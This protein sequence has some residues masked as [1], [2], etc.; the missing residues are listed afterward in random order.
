MKTGILLLLILSVTLEGRAGSPDTLRMP[1]DVSAAPHS[2][3]K[4][5]PVGMTIP[6]HR[7]LYENYDISRDSFPQNE[8]SVK[9]N[10]R[11]PQNVV[12]AWRDF[13]TG[14][15]PAVR[16]IGYSYSTDGGTTWSPSM[17]LPVIDTTHPRA[18]DPVVSS[19]T[20]GNFYVATIS[21]TNAN[22]NG[23]ILIY[24]STDRGQTFPVAYVAQGDTGTYEDKEWMICDLT[25][26]ISLYKN[27]LYLA[28][29][30][31]QGP[32]QGVLS[33]K[34]T[35]G[36]VNWTPPLRMDQTTGGVGSTQ[37]VGAGG[38]LYTVWQWSSFS[39]DLIVFVRSTDG[40]ETF[41]RDT[42]V[43]HGPS[44]LVPITP[45]NLT[46]PSIAA[47]ISNGPMRGNVYVV[48]SDARNGDPDIFLIKSTNSGLSWPTPIRVNDDSVGN[49][50]LQCWP[51]IAANDSGQLAV[52][53]YDARSTFDNSVVEAWLATSSDGGSTFR[54]RR[55]SSVATP[56]AWP[57]LDVRFGEY[58]NVDYKGNR[59]VPVWTDERAGG[60]DMDIYTAIVDLS[61]SVRHVVSE[62]PTLP[63]LGQ[64][65]P[66]PFNPTTRIK[67]QVPTI[68]IV[69]LKVFDVL[70]REVATLVN[71]KLS[72]GS[73][74][75]QFVADHLAS[76]VYF[77]RL[78]AGAYVETKRMLLL[79]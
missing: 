69:M 25:K 19:D 15:D 58:I 52:L 51:W 61:S 10:A 16:R 73:Y 59:I 67:F 39:E 79:R 8:P 66:N 18:S 6:A 77:Y 12:A 35:D 68:S 4:L 75:V 78:Q 31:A 40:G 7:S 53:Y 17:L 46:L 42:I 38:E 41:T 11:Y 57:N 24:K 26:G 36:G 30:R 45:L 9:F 72:S 5:P 48:W 56:S 3:V 70:G 2:N 33:S 34:S 60:Y 37:A 44:P 21:I 54:N 65:Y 76:G 28:W 27:T 22:Q 49:G 50:K 62:V 29:T 23:E 14:V 64:N 1:H 55:L 71:E 47:D 63:E 13:R 74:S 43:A 32:G 20:L